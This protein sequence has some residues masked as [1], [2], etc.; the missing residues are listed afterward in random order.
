M[1]NLKPFALIIIALIA[2]SCSNP[3]DK[4]IS[5]DC[6]YGDFKVELILNK[7]TMTYDSYSN[8]L[9]YLQ[10]GDKKMVKLI[11][12][13]KYRKEGENQYILTEPPLGDEFLLDR[14]TLTMTSRY[15]EVQ[16]KKIELPE[17]YLNKDSGLKTQI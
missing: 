8:I 15:G 7:K 2:V 12:N 4:Y 16:C 5:L 11:S 6:T 3:E 10:E 17:Y 1:N 13:A 14:T 9:A